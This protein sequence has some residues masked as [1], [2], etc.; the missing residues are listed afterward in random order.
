MALI[1]ASGKDEFFKAVDEACRKAVW[2]AVGTID[3]NVPRVRMVHPTWEGDVLWFA[4][5]SGSPKARPISR[6][7]MAKRVAES[8]MSIT[9]DPRSRKY[10]AIAVA[11]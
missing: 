7:A 11:R 3:G 5:G 2:A 10:S 1:D 4:T 8:I 6:W 9:L